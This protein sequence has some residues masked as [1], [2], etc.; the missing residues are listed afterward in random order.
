MTLSA[1]NI[2]LAIWNWKQNQGLAFQRGMWFYS[3]ESECVDH[4]LF[5]RDVP[6]HGQLGKF[7]PQDTGLEKKFHNSGPHQ[8]PLMGRH[9][10]QMCAFSISHVNLYREFSWSIVSII[11]F[12]SL[13]I[14]QRILHSWQ[15]SPF[16]NIMVSHRK[17]RL[18]S[19][20]W[21]PIDIFIKQVSRPGFTKGSIPGTSWQKRLAKLEK[22]SPWTINTKVKPTYH[23]GTNGAIQMVSPACTG[24]LYY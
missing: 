11:F 13:D 2:F 3:L 14:F 1:L 23:C 22:S 12:I 20:Q 18:W 7:C 5:P 8:S 4:T 6:Q 10:F 17:W 24:Y 15:S 9:D 21:I 16:F 19:Y